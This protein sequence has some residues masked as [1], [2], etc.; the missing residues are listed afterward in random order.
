LS[1]AFLGTRWE[2][3]PQQFIKERNFVTS[4]TIGPT[5][6]TVKMASGSQS[7]AEILSFKGVKFHYEG[8]I[9]PTVRDEETPSFPWGSAPK[10][11]VFGSGFN[12]LA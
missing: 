2:D 5:I 3:K 11:R 10:N 6:Y 1:Q 12:S 7:V 9:S 4:I 8:S